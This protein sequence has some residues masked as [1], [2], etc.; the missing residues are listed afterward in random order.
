MEYTSLL[1]SL[2]LLFVPTPLGAVDFAHESTGFPTW[3]RLF[4]LWLEREIQLLV[5]DTTFALH[6]WDWRD[7]DQR[8]AYFTEDR[9]GRSNNGNVE[10]TLFED[11]SNTCWNEVTDKNNPVPICDPT[12]SARDL[13]RCPDETVCDSDTNWPT[14][15]DV[16][17]AVSIEDYDMSPFNK[18]IGKDMSF[19]N[20]MEGF[21]SQSG[22]CTDDD[23]CTYNGTL[24]LTRMLH[25]SVSI[26]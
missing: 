25:N 4:L 5:G 19:R 23:L 11:W 14:S 12:Q 15:R 17:G 1:H 21:V 8:R 26:M 6:Y 20:T 9:L 13:R 2:S 10:G 3:H 16:D 7:S 22:S 24:S 18:Y